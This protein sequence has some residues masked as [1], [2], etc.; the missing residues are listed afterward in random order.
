MFRGDIPISNGQYDVPL[1]GVAAG[2]PG[3]HAST[4]NQLPQLIEA[5]T[6]CVENFCQV[7]PG[8]NVLVVAEFDSDPLV[9]ASFMTAASVAGAEVASITV[10]PFSAGGH[11]AG[12]P[13]DMLM[14]AYEQADVVI[15]CTYFEFAHSE[16][17]FFSEIFGSDQR[18]CSVIMAATPGALVTSGRF[19]IGLYMEIAKRAYRFLEGCKTIRYVTASGTDIVFENPQ[20]IGYSEPLTPGTWS[21]F[22][23]MGI[24]FYPLNANGIFVPD[25]TTIHG[26]PLAPIK[27]TVSNGYVTDVEAG[28]ESDVAAVDSYANGKYYLRHTVI[29][30]NPKTRTFNAPQ[31]ERERAAGMAYLGVDGTG[32][33]GIID[34]NKAGRAHLDAIFD[35]PTVY[36]DDKIMVDRRKLLILEDEELLELAKQY[37]EPR[38]ILAQNPFIW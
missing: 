21:I 20:G 8:E 1:S 11:R 24:N 23:P 26:R 9:V 29:G 7:Q 17:T 14:G 10:K 5:A 30:L 34:R 25:E 15:A 4:P 31:F 13:G 33:D 12:A 28:A 38:R 32:P 22:P 3:H 37:G 19:P 27:F 36:I 6:N 2:Y 16:K 18:V 35:T